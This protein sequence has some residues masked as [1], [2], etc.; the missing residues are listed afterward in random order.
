MKNKD[1]LISAIKT[2]ILSDNINF[3]NFIFSG[4]ATQNIKKM[5]FNQFS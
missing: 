4:K 1:D 5:F 2:I 3:N